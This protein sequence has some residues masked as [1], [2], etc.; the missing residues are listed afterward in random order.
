MYFTRLDCQL[1]VSTLHMTVLFRLDGDVNVSRVESISIGFVTDLPTLALGNIPRRSRKNGVSSYADSTLVV[2]VTPKA[3]ILLEYEPSLA[4]YTQVGENWDP[5]E[6]KQD[7]RPGTAHE[8]VA[9]SV[10]PSQF[11]LGLSGATLVLLNLSENDK[12]QV[13][14]QVLFFV[15]ACFLNEQQHS[16]S[17]RNLLNDSFDNRE[18]S[19]VSCTPLDPS[20]FFSTLIAV[21][22]WGSNCVEIFSLER[23][24]PHMKSLCK[25]QALPSL[26]RALLLQQFSR[27]G[28]EPSCSSDAAHLLV[29]LGD[30]NVVSFVFKDNRLGD[31]KFTSLGNGPVCMTT[32]EVDGKPAV[33]ASG[34]RAAVFFWERNRLQ[35]S[36]VMLKVCQNAFPPFIL[37][38]SLF[39]CICSFR[40]SLLHLV[41]IQKASPSPWSWLI[42]LGSLSAKRKT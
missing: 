8:I 38:L 16:N 40:T 7:N 24:E 27:P 36:P 12:F 21:S 26:P 6:L 2:Q 25:T 41:S 11:V 4:E 23:T 30:G 32:C 9:A 31:S 37:P 20:K 39:S 34:S 10:N 5:K 13:I 17:H 1:L 14:R 28:N 35:N 33:F 15:S 19:M 18:I 42:V 22:F 29:G 3:L